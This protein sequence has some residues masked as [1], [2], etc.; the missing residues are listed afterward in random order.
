MVWYASEDFY[1][2]QLGVEIVDGIEIP[3]YYEPN[4]W[5][6]SNSDYVNE[7]P[8]IPVYAW[9]DQT[10]MVLETGK[11]FVDGDYWI[12]DMSVLGK[13]EEITQNML[14]GIKVVPNP[15]IV[16]SAFQEGVNG[17]RLKFTP[18]PNNCKITIYTISGEIVDVIN[19]SSGGTAW[20][21]LKNQKGY[22]VAPGLYIFRAETENELD[23]IGKFAIVR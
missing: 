10:K 2:Q 20:W 22:D 5:V 16:S 14:E 11:W 7:N 15:Y 18:L 8:W 21:D 9:E 4:T 6:D 23:F 1:S 17:N 19:H 12:A 13:Q 3:V